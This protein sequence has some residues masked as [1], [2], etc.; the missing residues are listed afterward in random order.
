MGIV[1]LNGPQFII[2]AANNTS[3][4]LVD[5]ISSQFIGNPLFEVLPEIENIINPL[6]TKVF[7]T[8]EAFYGREFP[9]EIN[10]YGQ[11]E[12]GFFNFVFQPLRSDGDKTV[13]IIV[14]ATEITDTVRARYAIAESE[15]AFRDYISA[16]PIPF[17]IYMGKEM[18]IQMVN[19]ALLKTWNKNSSV[20][21]KTF[22]E[23][24][25]ELE[26]QP[27]YQLLDD[28]Y[29]TGIAYH[30]DE[31]KVDLMFNGKMQTFY[32]NF[33]YTPLKNAEGNT[34]GVLNTAT[35]ITE[36]V[37][38]KR[39]LADAEERARLAVE[40]GSMGTFDLNLLTGEIHC[41][42]RFYNIFGSSEP[43]SREE[44]IARIIPEDLPIRQKAYEMALKTG[45]LNYEVRVRWN[46]NSLHWMK[47][48]AKFFYNHK[49][50]A[51]RLLGT[52]EDITSEKNILQKIEESEKH[53]RNLIQEAPVPKA[54]LHGPDYIVEIANDAML[55]LWG[56]D[57]TVVGK[58][59][60]DALPELKG[61]P[62]LQILDEVYKTGIT[63]KG[64]ER[65]VFMEMKGN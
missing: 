17:A 22:T 42:S 53:F 25:P 44:G 65:P 28:V 18:R 27:F 20:I 29:N 10:R 11:K 7:E 43:L 4:Q 24:L 60:I 33:T 3:L 46:D 8:G 15:K 1:I 51:I 45:H 62:Y 37:L 6:L 41:S 48:N 32:F 54:L 5:K 30:T 2:E 13:G 34:Y 35:D 14:T 56:K 21:G 12:K 52:T 39:N 58:P 19:E 57:S 61:Q 47:M 50:K 49:G 63:Y 40:A 59:L 9:V 64:N 31:A 26:G 38:A 36:Q 23:A 16:S 55:E